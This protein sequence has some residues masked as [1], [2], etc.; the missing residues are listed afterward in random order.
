MKKINKY[1][2]LQWYKLGYQNY[3]YFLDRKYICY[4]GKRIFFSWKYEHF[5]DV[6]F[7]LNGCGYD[8]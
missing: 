6:V 1:I 8:K 3:N 2:D 5:H 4:S 7:I